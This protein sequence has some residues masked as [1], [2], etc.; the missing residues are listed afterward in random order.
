MALDSVKERV[1]CIRAADIMKPLAH[2]ALESLGARLETVELEDGDWLFRQGDTADALFV[3]HEGVL[4]VAFKPDAGDAIEAEIVAGQP[5]GE[6]QVLTGGRRTAGARAVGYCV[7]V[8]VAADALREVLAEAPDA[9]EHMAEIARRRLL[10]TH[11][12]AVLGEFFGPLDEILLAGI[13][14]EGDWV[15]LRRGDTLF[16]A[17]EA[18]D[19]L[20]LVISGRLRALT[21]GVG[22]EERL[23]GEIRRGESIGEMA[24]LSGE[25]RA[26]TVRAVRDSV[27]LRFDRE[28][29]D[30]LLSEHPPLLRQLTRVLASRLAGPVVSAPSRA[31][32]ALVPAGPGVPLEAFAERFSAALAQHGSVRRLTPERL[33]TA[34]ETPGAAKATDGDPQELRVEVY[35]DECEARHDFV[36][37]VCDGEPGPWSRRCAERADVQFLVGRGGDAPIPGELELELQKIPDT[38]ALDLVLTHS[39]SAERPPKSRGWLS[40]RRVRRFHHV[41]PELPE[42]MTRLARFAA[43]RPVGLALGGGGPLGVV[44]L[45]A[46]E[47]IRDAGLGLDM[48]AGTGIGAHLA[49]GLS[50]GWDLETA[51]ERALEAASAA[52]P[53]RRVAPASASA[54][55]ERCLTDQ[56]GNLQLEDSWL[57]VMVVPADLVRAEP[58]VLTYGAVREVLQACLTTPGTMQPVARG[59]SRLVDGG[60]VSDEPVDALREAGVEHILS[61]DPAPRFAESDLAGLGGAPAPSSLLSLLRRPGTARRASDLQI[62]IPVSGDPIAG[63][64]DVS[65]LVEAGR[66]KARPLVD[67]WRTSFER[68]PAGV[69]PQ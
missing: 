50:L 9:L 32:I 2:G 63:S 19:A 4:R 26:A 31:A 8:R 54:R 22:G 52:L 14:A 40:H 25:P 47:A 65:A 48:V 69:E 35:L 64:S 27:L 30:R 20:H 53:G 17:R 11:Q 59:K 45:G 33:E 16:R 55:L 1:D 41:R 61:V 6:I 15:R 60:Y 44:Q 38:A 46:V 13:E 3:V 62:A 28:A 37:Y 7:L 18:A 5:V 67:A 57:P 24:L 39:A 29:F 10:Y 12:R 58:R 21:E 36:L 51:R 49:V 43:G 56:F 23:L 42:D 34:L 68:R 66:K